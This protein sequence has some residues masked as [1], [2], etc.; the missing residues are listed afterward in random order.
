VRPEPPD[1]DGAVERRRRKGRRVLRVDLHH[2]HIVRVTLE[3]LSRRRQGGGPS[4]SSSLPATSRY[5]PSHDLR[6]DHPPRSKKA[7]LPSL[8]THHQHHDLIT[9]NKCCA[10]DAI[11]LTA[12]RRHTDSTDIAATMKVMTSRRMTT[13]ALQPTWVHSQFLSQSHSLMVISSDA[14]PRRRESTSSLRRGQR[15]TWSF[16]Q[17]LHLQPRAP[18]VLRIGSLFFA[19]VDAQPLYAAP[20][21]FDWYHWPLSPIQ[22]VTER[23]RGRLP[24]LSTWESVGWTSRKRT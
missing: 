12:D 14:L 15:I 24:C 7:T 19:A 16:K 3:H 20:K 22:H 18:G 6:D 4:A 10:N 21:S 5:E 2:H 17:P 9:N 8:I 1:F 23:G 13:Q 11:R